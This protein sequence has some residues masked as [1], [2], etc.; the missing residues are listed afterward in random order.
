MINWLFLL[1]LISYC[2]AEEAK[3]FEIKANYLINKTGEKV[4]FNDMRLSICKDCKFEQETLA[5][6]LMGNS[7]V[8]TNIFMKEKSNE[9]CK[10]FKKVIFNDIEFIKQLDKNEFNYQF[11]IENIPAVA[12]TDEKFIGTSSFALSVPFSSKQN[13]NNHFK[14]ILEYNEENPLAGIYILPFSVKHTVIPG[15]TVPKDCQ[16]SVQLGIPSEEIFITFDV[17]WRKTGG[18]LQSFMDRIHQK[19]RNL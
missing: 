7:L 9:K 6:V 8:H 1:S 15:E 14:I 10:V 13:I 3:S 12:I 19:K 11:V 18:N 16:S 17:D 4:E 2:S 5:N